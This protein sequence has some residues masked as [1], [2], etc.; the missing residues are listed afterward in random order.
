MIPHSSTHTV[1]THIYS[2]HT[3]TVHTHIQYTHIYSTHTY[4]VHTHIYSTHTYTVHTHIYST[5]T[6]TVHTHIYSTH[7]YIQYTHI[8]NGTSV[9]R[10][11]WD[12]RKVQFREVSRLEKVFMSS[13]YRERRTRLHIQSKEGSS[14]QGLRFGEVS[15]Y[16]HTQRTLYT[17]YTYCSLH[18]TLYTHTQRTLYTPYTYCSLHCTQYTQLTLVHGSMSSASVW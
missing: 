16:T 6:Y 17:L 7:T 13:K 8:Y 1:H 11:P 5:H 15:L 12:Q 3:Y 2:T 10:N 14:L 9:N 18:C 4:T